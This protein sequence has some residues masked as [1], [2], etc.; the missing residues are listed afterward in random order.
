MYSP[1]ERSSTSVG[2]LF[3]VKDKKCPR[4]IQ[5]TPINWSHFRSNFVMVLQT[6]KY[7]FIWIGRTSSHTERL[8]AF[9]LALKFRTHSK[10]MPEIVTVDDGYEQSMSETK[11]KVWN[12]Y[13]SLSQ[14][15]V[16]P[17]DV[18]VTASV[19]TLRL[20]RGGFQNGI[21]RFEELKSSAIQQRDLSDNKHAYIIDSGETYGVFIW[22]GRHASV[23]EKAEAMRNARG[24]VK[25]VS[26]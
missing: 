8:N 4:C 7:I 17:L 12:E 6:T 19:P 1:E 11:K 23:K 13:L 25:K 10:S 3:H 26:K 21:Y 20:Y 2:K 14:R 5:R 9:H 15:S 18:T 22:V 16:L 24:F